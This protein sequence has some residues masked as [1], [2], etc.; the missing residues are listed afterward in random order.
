MPFFQ[1]VKQHVIGLEQAV[2]SA[3]PPAEHQIE[4][5]LLRLKTLVPPNDKS[6]SLFKVE[7]LFHW[8]VFFIIFVTL[9]TF[10]NLV[11][12]GKHSG[13]MTMRRACG[14]CVFWLACAGG[15]CSFIFFSRGSDAA[16]NWATGYI[17]EWMLSVDNL[18]VFRTIFVVFHTPDSQKHKP[19][20]WGIIGAIFF[21]M[22]FFALEE[23][24][25]HAFG[26]MYL[27]LGAFLVYTAFKIVGME[28]EDESPTDNEWF[29]AI[30]H[31]LHVVDSYAPLPKFFARIPVDAKTKEPVLPD[32]TPP[33]LPKDYDPATCDGDPTKGRDIDFQSYATRLCLVVI[34]LELT[35]VIFAVDS[36]SAIVA[37]IP[38]LYLA[39][40]ACV[41]AMLGLRASFFV[42]D[43]IVKLFSLLSYGVAAILCFIGVKLM[44]KQWYH[45]SESV[46]CAILV[47]TMAVSMIASVIA[48][49]YF[50]KEESEED[51][52]DVEEKGAV[53][54]EAQLGNDQLKP[55]EVN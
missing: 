32:W 28:E 39:Y 31:K 12:F 15:F 38:D 35:D 2:L 6:Y 20:F 52:E 49:R 3:L 44:L 8:T 48:D 46:T 25:V 13:P 40:T 26:F 24:V 45:I 27:I 21:R 50:P 7:D 9:L 36:V 54:F 14:Y 51:S 5:E 29:V 53:Q 34:C 17:L 16:F 4:T 10:D 42:I 47:G 23:V 18:F 37:Q 19:L 41:F 1:L 33:V 55:T 11:L 30:R 22:I 43:E